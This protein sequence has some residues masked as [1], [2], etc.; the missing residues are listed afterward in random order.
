ME[1][2]R[3]L[4]LNY[5]QIPTLSVLLTRNSLLSLNN[6]LINFLVVE[7]EYTVKV[8]TG[9]VWGA[10]TDANIFINMYGDN[11]DTGER[12]LKDSQT[13]LNKFERKAVRLIIILL[14]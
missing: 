11:G 3:K 12:E 5:H 1:N 10:G 8:F 2:C 9:D 14:V 6:F 13:N 7:V 4:S